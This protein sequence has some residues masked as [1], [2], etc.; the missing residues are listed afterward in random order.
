M[1]RGK[2]DNRRKEMKE[3]KK[4]RDREREAEMERAREVMETVA[5]AHAEA[6]QCSHGEE[7]L[8]RERDFGGPFPTRQTS[9]TPDLE[10]GMSS[11]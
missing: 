2:G 6:Q 9:I 7:E 5:L 4:K 10:K 3:S 8:H 1:G 11:R